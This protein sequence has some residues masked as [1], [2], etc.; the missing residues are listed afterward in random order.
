MNGAAM[1]RF[2]GLS[3][4][5][6]QAG[7]VVVY[8]NGTGLSSLLLFWDAGDFAA[9]RQTTSDSSRSCSMTSPPW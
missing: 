5:A 1:A 2:S 3:E 7:F 9:G 8:P 6:D 4:K